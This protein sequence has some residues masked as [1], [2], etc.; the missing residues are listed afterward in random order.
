[1]TLLRDNVEENAVGQALQKGLSMMEGNF[2][3]RDIVREIVRKWNE[4][5]WVPIDILPPKG[6]QVLFQTDW[7]DEGNSEFDIG[8]YDDIGE[9]YSYRGMPPSRPYTRWRFL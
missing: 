8:H 5:C 6:W 3:T 7:D 1:M 2:L 9:K 4:V